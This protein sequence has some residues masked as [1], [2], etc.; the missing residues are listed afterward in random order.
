[1]SR[2]ARR[3][4][5]TSAP[6]AIRKSGI[7]SAIITVPIQSHVGLSEVVGATEAIRKL[8]Y[9]NNAETQRY[10]TKA[11]R[12]MPQLLVKKPLGQVEPFPSFVICL[13]KNHFLRILEILVLVSISDLFY[14]GIDTMENHKYRQKNQEKQQRRYQR[15][16]SNCNPHPKSVIDHSRAQS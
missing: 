14:V 10:N 6:K 1:V 12:H 9:K 3:T 4:I 8:G 5:A 15:H 2:I 11:F 13:L 16:N 7:S